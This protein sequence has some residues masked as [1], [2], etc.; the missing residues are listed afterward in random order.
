VNG[1]GAILDATFV[2]R[3]DR[4][5]IVRLAHKRRIPLLL[6]H[7]A[8]SEETTQER[9]VQREAEG[10]DVSDG[11]W[12]I[13]VQQKDVFEAIDEIPPAVCLELNTDAPPEALIAAC[14]KFLRSRLAR[15]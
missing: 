3:A 12:E 1:K 7:C 4:E 14:E 9:L 2:R 10:K 11:R 5:K 15:G 8:A 13:Y 6:I